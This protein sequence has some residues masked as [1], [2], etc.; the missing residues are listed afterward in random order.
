MQV[1]ISLCLITLLAVMLEKLHL[2]VKEQ[3]KSGE[4]ILL[5][6]SVVFFVCLGWIL[7]IPRAVALH[8]PSYTPTAPSAYQ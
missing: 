6:T 5:H 2:C 1:L 4:L 3:P 7:R 8:V